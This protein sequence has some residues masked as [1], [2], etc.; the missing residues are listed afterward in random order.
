MKE[1]LK[2]LL[3]LFVLALVVL[4]YVFRKLSR[5]GMRDSNKVIRGRTDEEVA[6]TVV[7]NKKDTGN[8][9]Q[10]YQDSR[11]KLEEAKGNRVY[12]SLFENLI[13][14]MQ[15][16]MGL[17][18]YRLDQ[19]SKDKLLEDLNYLVGIN[20]NNELFNQGFRLNEQGVLEG[21]RLNRSQVEQSNQKRS[22]AE[23][24]QLIASYENERS[25]LAIYN[26]RK[27]LCAALA[28]SIQVLR[29]MVALEQVDQQTV[30]KEIQNIDRSFRRY[31]FEFKYYE[32]FSESS[33]DAKQFLIGDE[34]SL[35]YPALYQNGA[36]YCDYVGRKKVS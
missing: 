10:R 12:A 1:F 21:F 16:L 34:W 18:Y 6:P 3:F 27:E 17:A 25:R 30:R 36:L 15:Q 9:L 5:S 33:N 4:L 22:E 32:D 19:A 35:D 20:L 29:N 7:E 31:G 11:L 8:L 14:R 24:K 2:I 13:P 26:E 28:K 23:L